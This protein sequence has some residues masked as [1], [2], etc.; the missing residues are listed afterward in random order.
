LHTT[1]SFTTATRAKLSSSCFTL[2]Q[3]YE[4]SSQT[5]CGEQWIIYD[6]FD[7]W[8][9]LWSDTGDMH[10]DSSS[11]ADTMEFGGL[12]VRILRQ[13]AEMFSLEKDGVGFLHRD[14]EPEPPA[15]GW[16]NHATVMGYFLHRL[17]KEESV[18]RG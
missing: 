11:I 1:S 5:P 6:G 15:V 12:R 13:G 4:S 9:G 16:A 2:V 10:F 7:L 3:S 14:G 18:Y 8:F 17:W